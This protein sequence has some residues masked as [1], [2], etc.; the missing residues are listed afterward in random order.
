MF[1]KLIAFLRLS[2]PFFL[3]GG[4]VL[5]AL[6]AFIAR[7]EGLPIDWRRYLLGQLLV[8]SLQLMTQYFNEYWDVEADRLNR[9]RTIFSGGSGIL[10]SGALSRETALAAALICLALSA[11][12]VVVLATQ[13]PLT[14]SVWVI[15]ALA[16]VGTFFYST[17]PLALVN[18][19]FGEMTA[20][21]VVAG[22]VPA[23]AQALQSGRVSE[24]TLAT[25]APLMAWCYT[26]LLAFEIPDFLSDE[27]AGKRTALVRLGR[28]RGLI[29]HNIVLLLG[30]GLVLWGLLFGLPVRVAY[31]LIVAAPLAA[32]QFISVR[33]LQ[34]GEPVS[35]AVLTFGAMAL[36]ALSAYL[37]ALGYWN[38]G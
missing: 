36:F 32:W 22:L 21:V 34:Q 18:S 11:V 17:P 28:K 9:A 35:F 3:L 6:G 14:L 27:A 30:V 33:R 26:M 7:Y 29:L 37:M 16:F 23:F 15:L 31:W 12:L 24:L 25:T 20:S 1:A 5:Y 10:P 13:Y 19:G 2:R 8:T 38:I 4:R